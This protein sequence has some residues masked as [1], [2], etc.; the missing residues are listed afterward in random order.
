MSVVHTWEFEGT[1]DDVRD[2]LRRVLA[3][4]PGVR[5]DDEDSEYDDEDS[6]YDDEDDESGMS[7]ALVVPAAVAAEILA[8]D[9]LRFGDAE[10]FVVELDIVVE[11]DGKGVITATRVDEIDLELIEAFVQKLGAVYSDFR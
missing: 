5:L 11:D 1:T 7:V 3:E 9:S 6:E 8:R 4:Y 2:V 10:P